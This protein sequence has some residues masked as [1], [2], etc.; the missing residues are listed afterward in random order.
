MKLLTPVQVGPLTLRNRVVMPAMH[1]VFTPEGE[2][3]D[4]LVDFYAARAAGG[5][6]LIIIGGCPVDEVAGMSAMVRVDDDRC[7]PGLARLAGVVHDHGACL[8]A[9]LYHG[10]RY[11]FSFMIGGRQALAP[12]PVRSKFTGEEP[13]EMTREDIERVIGSF[14]AATRRVRA[15]GLDAVEI[16]ASAGYLI[17]QFLSPLTNLRTDE[18]GGSFENRMRFG[19][20]VAR[21][22]REAAGPDMAVIVR[23][24]GNDFM[25]GSHT[26]AQSAEFAA[27]LEKTGVDAFNVTGGWHETRVP[28]I[29]MNL[30]RGGYVYL[31]QGIKASTSLPVMACNRLNHPRTAERI[32]RQG[33]AD[34]VGVARGHIA[35]PEWVNKTAAGRSD[36]INLCLGCNQGCFDHVFMLQ[37]VGCLVNPL[38]GFEGEI[39]VRPA[40]TRKK[41]LVA[42]GGPAG[43]TFARVA[44]E[45]GHTVT[46][47]EKEDRLG[48]QI[49]IAATLRERGEFMTLIR[50][51]ETLARKAGVK[52]I[53]ERA[54]DPELVAREAPEVVVTA[55]GGRPVPAPFPGGD[56]PHVV[57]AWDVLT[58]K[59][60]VGRKVAVCGGG[61]VGC[62]TALYLAAIGTITPDEL[63]F[64]FV[65]EAETA[66]ELYRLATRGIKEVTLLEMTGRV[67]SDIGQTTGWIIRQDLRR[68]GVKVMTNTKVLEVRPEGVLVAKNGQETLVPADTVV[69]ALGTVPEAALY[70]NLSGKHPR[71]ISVG[72]CRQPAKAYDAVHAAF[73]AALEI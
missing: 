20:E 7:I 38:A 14:A 15:A 1:L 49:P 73:K 24:A 70:E 68:A 8:A 52:I 66:E 29:P 11:S 50:S 25:P 58:E 45:R 65:N 33:R 10:G 61:A 67:G 17:S 36:E 39:K 69:L 30:P 23:L 32:L 21:A 47:Y 19:L 63:H 72:D 26:N 13:R 43:L 42:G 2:V 27:A 3:N 60:D 64:L 41:V 34:L 54:V 16:L 62:E 44:A 6:G 28:Q 5:V 37:P 55:T 48:G 46:L 71:V 12:S 18:Y 31:A 59:A 53:L 4:R 22:V 35:D 9:Q 51:A 57:Q 40:E 56:L